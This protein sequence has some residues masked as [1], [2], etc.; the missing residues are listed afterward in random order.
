VS[1]TLREL[2]EEARAK[3][4][5]TRETGV[6]LAA[7]TPGGNSQP[8]G[9]TPPG[10]K[11]PER[12]FQDEV[13]AFAQA[14]G[15][16][17]VAVRHAHVVNKGKDAKDRYTTPFLYDGVGWPDLTL[18]RERLVVVELK[19]GSNKPTKAQRR[20]LAALARA[21]IETYIWKPED[22]ELIRRVL[23]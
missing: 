13:V 12:T 9:V 20:W 10:R 7:L 6:N 4:L 14:N 21:G 18:C 17:A 5:V 1:K 11:R 22:W 3:G 19:V 16:L 23:T 2:I 15:W 8:L